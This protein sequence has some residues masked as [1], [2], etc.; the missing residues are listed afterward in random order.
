MKGCGK[1]L[2]T[3]ERQV[4]DSLVCNKY[5]LCKKCKKLAGDELIEKEGGDEDDM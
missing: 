2:K 1:K 3:K 5:Q 4:R